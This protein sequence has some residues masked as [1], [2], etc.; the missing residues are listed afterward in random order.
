MSSHDRTPEERERAAAERAARRAAAASTPPPPAP[1]PPPPV[2]PPPVAPQR[3]ADPPRLPP[4]NNGGSAVPPAGHR[5]RH[6]RGPRIV[7]ALVLLAIVAGIGWFLVS[8]FQPGKGDGS[9]RVVVKI[10]NGASVGDIGDLLEQEGVVDSSTFFSL[11]ARL[12]GDASDLK[13]GTY[14]LKEDMS[15][16]AAL[17]ALKAGPPKP[18]IAKVVIPE[19]L[20]RSEAAPVV[21]KAGLTGSYLA[22]TKR[23]PELNPRKYGAPKGTTSLE[24]FLF[25]ATYQLKLGSPVDRLVAQQLAA[26]KDNLAELDLKRAKKKNL[27]AYDVVT[28]ASMIER[29]AQVP[30]ERKLVAAVIWNRLHEGMPL[31]IDATIRFATHNWTRPLR[32]SDL[33]RDGPYNT[34]LRRG[35][36]PTPIGNPGLASLKAAAQPAKVSYLYYVVKPGT[37]G[38]HAFSSTDAKFQRDADA[39]QRAL[40]KNGGKSP[41]TCP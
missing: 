17:D 10:P 2:A 19:G 22:A 3:P 38:E 25:P 16:G 13:S 37:C 41:T 18:T 40:K 20:S 6:R 8:L 39:Y 9:G 21:K 35:L 7:A 23:S 11:R 29:E 32:V 1:A 33:Q 26:F 27:T 31:G 28:I 24:G 36:P 12:A 34:R 4:R 5:P 14:V 15:Y 30:R